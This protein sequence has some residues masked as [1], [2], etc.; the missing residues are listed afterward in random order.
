MARA[1]KTAGRKNHEKITKKMT[2]NV[3]ENNFLIVHWI[4]DGNIFMSVN[5]LI[6]NFFQKKNYSGGFMLGLRTAETTSSQKNTHN[7]HTRC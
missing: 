4:E 3:D 5:F 1:V 6:S 2:K 7:P